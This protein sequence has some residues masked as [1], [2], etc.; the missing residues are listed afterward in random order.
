MTGR[1]AS[2]RR[3]SGAASED[4]AMVTLRVER[5]IREAVRRIASYEEVPMEAITERAMMTLIDD[6]ERRTG[7]PIRQA[8][9]A[10]K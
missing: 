5:K 7:L 3:P 9:R 4:R 1:Q 8:R 6:F 10:V 2:S